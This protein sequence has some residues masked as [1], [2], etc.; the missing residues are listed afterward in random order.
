MKDYHI[1]DLDIT[2]FQKGAVLFILH[3]LEF[4]GQEEQPLVL[5]Q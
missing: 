1:I 2:L 4:L 5:C 3:V